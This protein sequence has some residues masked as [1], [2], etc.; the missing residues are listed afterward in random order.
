MRAALKHWVCF[1]LRDSFKS[2]FEHVLEK[3]NDISMK[4]KI[5]DIDVVEISFRH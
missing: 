1:Y 3:L 4:L 2:H 5:R